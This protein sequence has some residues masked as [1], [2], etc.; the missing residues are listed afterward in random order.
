MKL[1]KRSE[2]NRDVELLIRGMNFIPNK[3]G[4]RMPNIRALYFDGP[5]LVDMLSAHRESVEKLPLVR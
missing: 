2:L 1:L 3:A 4:Q 5:I